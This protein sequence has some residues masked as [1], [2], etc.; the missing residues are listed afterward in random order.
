MVG[1][2][3]LRQTNVCHVIRAL[4]TP[5]PVQPATDQTQIIAS[6][7]VQIAIFKFLQA[8]ASV[9]VLLLLGMVTQ[10]TGHVNHATS[11]PEAIHTLVRLAMGLAQRIVLLAMLENISTLPMAIA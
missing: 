10:L 8:L 11:I 5:F 1:M 3:L 7:A 6:L 2:Q 9:H 4:L